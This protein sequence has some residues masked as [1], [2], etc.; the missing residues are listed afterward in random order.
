MFPP[1]LAGG[2]VPPDL[3][4]SE[5]GEIVEAG[6]RWWDLRLRVSPRGR[7]FLLT[8]DAGPASALASKAD[9]CAAPLT[10]SS[11]IT[12][13]SGAKQ[14]GRSPVEVAGCPVKL[15]AAKA[16]SRSARLTVRAPA[17]GIVRL[18]GKGLGRRTLTFTSAGTKAVRVRLSRTG[19]RSLRKHHK[20]LVRVS[21]SY[22]PATSASAGGEPVKPSVSRTRISFRAR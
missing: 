22:A 11:S 7:E 20:L 14:D 6:L 13:Q 5:R 3:P 2:V 21:A 9:L 16:G 12:A 8:L 4:V 1:V 18:T 17:A 10:L 19:L 15:V